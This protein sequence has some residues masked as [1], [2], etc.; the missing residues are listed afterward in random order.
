M[1]LINFFSLKLEITKLSQYLPGGRIFEAKSQPTSV[2]YKLLEV[3]STEISRFLSVLRDIELEHFP[4]TT[5]A[6]IEEWEKALGIPDQCFNTTGSIDQRRKQILMKYAFMNVTTVEDFVRLGNLLGFPIRIVPGR[7]F[8]ESPVPLKEIVFTMKIILP[9]TNTVSVFDHIF[10]FPFND[11]N[12][13]LVQCV[14][15]RVKPANVNIIYEF[16]TIPPEDVSESVDYGGIYGAISGLAGLKFFGDPDALNSTTGDAIKSFTD[17]SGND[18]HIVQGISASQPLLV[19]PESIA[20]PV[21]TPV[22]TLGGQRALSFDGT[23]DFYTIPVGAIPSGNSDFSI[24]LL[25]NCL[26]Y[27]GK[28]LLYFGDYSIVSP[29]SFSFT[30][31]DEPSFNTQWASCFV[32]DYG[33]TAGLGSDMYRQWGLVSIRHDSSTNTMYLNYDAT[34]GSF[35]ASFVMPGDLNIL[36]TGF[37]RH[38]MGNDAGNWVQGLVGFLAIY[39]AFHD[40]SEQAS[41]V[42][43]ID[44]DKSF[45]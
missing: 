30:G 27:S 34:T 31:W 10:D 13:S 22:P 6:F 8:L 9:S 1:S 32:T 17:L 26:V 38:L 14:I 40:N 15:N 24:Y 25:I 36:T 23:D 45:L 37:F 41:V 35:A 18:N 11:P 21:M 42:S 3:V 33:V 7:Q 4:G 19:L 16:E 5:T 43:A 12:N 44:A 20:F 28:P 29:T 39:H 2:I